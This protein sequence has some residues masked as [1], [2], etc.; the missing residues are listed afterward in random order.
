MSANDQS[1]RS[2]SNAGD[3]NGDGFDDVIIGAH[4]DDP[5]GNAESGASFVVF[6]KENGHV[7][8]SAVE[9][10]GA[11]NLGF[12]INGVGAGDYAGQSVSAAG[13]VNGDGFDDLLVGAPATTPIGE[14]SGSAYLVYGKGDSVPVEL[15]A[16]RGDA[17]LGLSLIHISEPTRLV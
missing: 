4:R 14:N 10:N 15:S 5:N 1:G 16:L 6:G 7:E 3:V 12:V 11:H 17:N 13:D 2:V 8:L 9:I